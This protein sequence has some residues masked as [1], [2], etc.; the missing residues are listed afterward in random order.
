MQ[1]EMMEPV[2][3]MP[4]IRLTLVGREIL[5]HQQVVGEVSLSP[6]ALK[7][8]ELQRIIPVPV[9]IIHQ[10]QRLES[11]CIQRPVVEDINR[12]LL[13]HLHSSIL[14]L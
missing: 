1:H 6:G 7:M 4:E 13:S 8:E 5:R 9:R 12:M 14:A 10:V 3:V 2:G 11:I